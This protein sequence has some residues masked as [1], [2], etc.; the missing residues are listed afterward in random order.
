M[1]LG[2]HRA[3]SHAS[4]WVRSGDP[5][6]IG[7]G[8]VALA[9]VG[10]P[11]DDAA[12]ASLLE[13]PGAVGRR[14]LYYAGMVGHDAVDRLARDPDAP[15]A[16]GGPVVAAPRLHGDRLSGPGATLAP[17]QLTPPETAFPPS[18]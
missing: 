13:Q 18:R 3:V 14:A 6:L 4:G 5:E 12:L 1:A 7:P 2:D 9:H 17:W 8:L 15:A 16:A 10:A 11:V